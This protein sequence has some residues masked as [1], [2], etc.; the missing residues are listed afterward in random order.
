LHIVA[1]EIKDRKMFKEA[2]VEK[3]I[4]LIERDV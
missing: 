1:L 4:D 3:V 2:D